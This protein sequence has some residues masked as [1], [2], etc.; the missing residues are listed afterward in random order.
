MGARGKGR[1]L[2]ARRPGRLAPQRRQR[3]SAPPHNTRP[4]TRTHTHCSPVEELLQV[5]VHVGRQ[6]VP[7]AHIQ[8][9]LGLG[10]SSARGGRGG[11][12]RARAWVG[13]VQRRGG[14]DTG[15]APAA[16]AAAA[17]TRP[18]PPPPQHPPTPPTPLTWLKV[19]ALELGNVA[20]GKVEDQVLQILRVAPQPVLQAVHKVA[21]VLRLVGG[22][23]LEHLGQRA[24]LGGM[25]VSVWGGCECVCVGGGGVGG[26]GGGGV[27]GGGPRVR[28]RCECRQAGA[29]TRTRA[30]TSRRAGTRAGEREG[31]WAGCASCPLTSLSSCSSKLSF[32]LRMFFINSPIADLPCA[33]RE[34]GAG[35]GAST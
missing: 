17:G 8:N 31:G 25:G 28:G 20:L 14:M 23:V 34:G 12:G 32:C 6:R 26:V 3:V 13:A 10:C 9:L 35:R 24:D 18:L 4:H 2:D 22:Q 7:D 15:A 16:P 19:D 21:C 11:R 33:G 30:Q 5:L 1:A 27:G 29:G